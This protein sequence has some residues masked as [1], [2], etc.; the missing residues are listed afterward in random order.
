ME[1]LV[2]DQWT[3]THDDLVL[4]QKEMDAGCHTVDSFDIRDILSIG[5][6]PCWQQNIHNQGSY[7]APMMTHYH[8]AGLVIN[9]DISN[10]IVLEIP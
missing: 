3:V 1:L 5:K 9:Y 6:F 8:N 10:T 4:I 2:M 7:T